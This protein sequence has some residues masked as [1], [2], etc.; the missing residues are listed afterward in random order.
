VKDNNVSGIVLEGIPGTG[1][2]TVLYHLLKTPHWQ[3]KPYISSVILSEHHTLRVL[4]NKRLD[5]SYTKQDSLDLLNDHVTNLEGLNGNL[6]QTSWLKRDRTAQ[7][8]PFIFE[9]FHLSHV[10]H[11]DDLEWSD[12]AGIDVRLKNL[13][14]KLLLFTLDPK[15]I[16]TR[17]IEDYKKAGWQ[18]YLKTLGNSELEI[19]EYFINKQQE[20]IELGNLSELDTIT[21]DSSKLTTSEIV[22]KIFSEWILY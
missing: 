1:K 3:N 7:K 9:R 17:I 2:T 8:L 16:K 14:T 15:D 21:I 18:N 5:K 19:T 12:V 6:K 20:F 4:E 22:K 11:H 10:Y 13:N